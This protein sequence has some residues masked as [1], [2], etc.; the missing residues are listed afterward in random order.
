MNF[1]GLGPGELLLIMVL[2]LI[3]FGPGKLPEI[4][5]GLGRAVREFRRATD[6]ITQEFSKELSLDSLTQPQPSQPAAA[7]SPAPAPEEP[8]PMA[9]P[10][11]EEPHAATEPIVAEAQQVEMPATSDGTVVELATAPKPRVRRSKAAEAENGDKAVDG[12]SA[13]RMR[14][15]RATARDAAPEE[16]AQPQQA[17]SLEA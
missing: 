6:S 12:S 17:E 3:V 14:K 16:A 1:L 8:H 9:A 15:L 10:V 7:P 5:Q 2:A 4:G 11:A 13:K